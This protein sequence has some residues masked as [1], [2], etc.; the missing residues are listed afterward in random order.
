MCFE[1]FVLTQVGPAEGVA[2]RNKASENYGCSLAMA[3]MLPKKVGFA[4]YAVDSQILP[5]VCRV[6]NC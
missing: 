3:D 4:C 5:N 1:R 2:R 6:S